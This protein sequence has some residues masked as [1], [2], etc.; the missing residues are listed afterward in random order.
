MNDDRNGEFDV[1][2]FGLSAR[3]KGSIII[4]MTV[5]MIG[6]FIFTI[7]SLQHQH[8]KIYSELNACLRSLGIRNPPEFDVKTDAQK[9]R[10]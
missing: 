8:D 6:G 7:M 10:L 9:P 2:G 4:L 3:M 1:S 5:A